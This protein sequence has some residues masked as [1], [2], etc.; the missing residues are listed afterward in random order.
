VEFPT[1]DLTTPQFMGTESWKVLRPISDSDCHLQ[2][3]TRKWHQPDP[4]GSSIHISTGPGV[5]PDM[6]C[7]QGMVESNSL[8]WSSHSPGVSNT[9]SMTPGGWSPSS[10]QVDRDTVNLPITSAFTVLLEDLEWDCHYAHVRTQVYNIDRVLVEPPRDGTQSCLYHIITT[11]V[12]Q[13]MIQV[14]RS[15]GNWYL[16]PV[17]QTRLRDFLPTN[18][19]IPPA[20]TQQSHSTVNPS[21]LEDKC[22]VFSLGLLFDIS[23]Q[24]LSSST[25]VQVI[26]I[27]GMKGMII[28]H[29]NSIQVKHFVTTKLFRNTRTTSSTVTLNTTEIHSTP[30]RYLRLT[31]MCLWTKD[32]KSWYHLILLFCYTLGM[33]TH[34]PEWHLTSELPSHTKACQNLTRSRTR[35]PTVYRS[36]GLLDLLVLGLCHSISDP[37]TNHLDSTLVVLKSPL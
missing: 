18:L 34:L 33:T 22:N 37:Q 21:N 19:Q 5:N 4:P 1:F 7:G 2:G 24:I 20:W 17:N 31:R 23:F 9:C 3:G 10:Q 12:G 26:N 16:Q 11:F 32:V 28:G 30:Q 14:R 36:L 8:A 6:T 35:T 15:L 25:S 27:H 29:V 13:T